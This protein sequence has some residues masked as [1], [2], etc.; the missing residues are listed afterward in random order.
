V[1]TIIE[2]TVQARLEEERGKEAAIEATAEAKIEIEDV[3][4]IIRKGQAIENVNRALSIDK[5]YLGSSEGAIPVENI[6][7]RIEL[8]NDAIRLDPASTERYEDGNNMY[9]LRGKDYFYLA[10]AEGNLA[11]HSLSR[12]GGLTPEQ[13]KA[14]TDAAFTKMVELFN[15]TLKDFDD[16]LRIGP[17]T[18]ELYCWTGYTFNFLGDMYEYIGKIAEANLAHGKGSREHAKARGMGYPSPWDYCP[19][20]DF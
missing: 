2:A 16:A 18:F 6:H 20:F 19:S 10:I 17:P 13:K 7:K 3:I 9:Y 11:D 12:G 5:G 4:E 8:F 14:V 15:L 1:T